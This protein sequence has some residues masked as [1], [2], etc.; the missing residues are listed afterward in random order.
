M[1]RTSRLMEYFLLYI[2]TKNKRQA[3]TLAR[4]LLQEGLI[5]CA[6]V[7]SG[8]ESHFRWEGKT[9]TAQECILFAKTTAA[10]RDEAQV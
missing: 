8:V 1:G 10:R 2:T 5:A 4:A 3:R 9:H 6:N 7:V